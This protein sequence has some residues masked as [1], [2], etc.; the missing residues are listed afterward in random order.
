MAR[1][2]GSFLGLLNY[3]LKKEITKGSPQIPRA[4]QEVQDSTRPSTTA[5]DSLH[6]YAATERDSMI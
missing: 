3:F 2:E 5:T 1:K 6:G 4:M